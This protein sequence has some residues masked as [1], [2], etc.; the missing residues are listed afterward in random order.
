MSPDHQTPDVPTS[1]ETAA[2][3]AGQSGDARSLVT[4]TVVLAIAAS[5]LGFAPILV[6]LSDLG[7]Q[8]IAFWR[9]ALA[10][11]AFAVWLALANLRPV[12][13]AAGRP[14]YVALGL[15]GLFFAGD[16][17]FWHAGIKL[18]TAANAALLSN[19]TPVI[20][21]IAAWVLF[22]ERISLRLA[23]AGL[24]AMAGAVLLAAANIRIAPERLVGDLL[25]AIT[26]LWYASYLLSVQRARRTTSTVLV[27]IVSTALAA[28]ISLAVTLVLGDTLFPA[29]L[30]GWLPLIGLGIVVHAGGQGGV[31]FGLGRVPAALAALIL[32]IQPI[33]AAIAGWLI[34]GEILVF[35]QWIGAGLV[36]AGVYSAQRIRT[37]K[38]R[39]GSP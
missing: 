35:S 11:P 26:A 39:R 31:A 14:N 33:V 2:A 36:L 22:G 13:A 19:L 3:G 25:S 37:A 5:L 23:L 15:A 27:M 16:L 21:A 28:I 1:L 29:T 8:P 7:P 10:L 20:V 30:A 32:L 18:T 34:F 12:R 24:V 17:A 9:L 38:I 4:G 6:K